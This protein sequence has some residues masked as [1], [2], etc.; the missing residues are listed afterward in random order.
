MLGVG[1]DARSRLDA[2]E[3]F[4]TEHTV[5]DEVLPAHRTETLEQVRDRAVHDGRLCAVLTA[6]ADAL[7]ESLTGG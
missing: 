5:A 2:A 6:E 1:A 3:C 4:L 7:C